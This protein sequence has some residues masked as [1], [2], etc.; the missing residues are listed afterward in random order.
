MT[1]SA[2]AILAHLDVVAAERLARAQNPAL[3]TRVAA[4]KAYQQARFARTHADLLTHAAYGPAARFFLDDLYG[5]HDFADRDAQFARIVPAITRLFPD[6]IVDTVEALGELHAL[7][8][9][10]DTQ[11]ALRLPDAS[12]SARHYL[13]AWQALGRPEARARQLALVLQL[14]HR[15]VR[16]T[17]SRWLRQTL[18]MMR[19]PARSAGLGALQTFL[20]RGFD[21]F[22]A[23]KDASVFLD[24]VRSR[25]SAVI[26][27]FFAADAVT[28]ATEMPTDWH[29]P[30]G[31][32]P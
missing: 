19:K 32:L 27:A 1:T 5:P 6:D 31:Q 13:L 30:I 9:Q 24:L 15:L 2:A 8:E 18:K 4:L 3:G 14:G 12:W 20:E 11:M 22:G 28:L 29:G 17:R 25:E 26:Q 21:T 7:S 16:Y 23:M 10:L